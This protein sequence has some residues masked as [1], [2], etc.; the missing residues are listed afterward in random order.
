MRRRPPRSTRTDTLCPYTTLFRSLHRVG[1][2]AVAD[3]VAA[4]AG[5]GRG[6][7]RGG[8]GQPRRGRAGLGDAGVQR[9][10]DGVGQEPVGLDHQRH[11]RRLDRDLHVVEADL[12][13]V[14]QLHLGRLDHRLG[15]DLTAVLLVELRVEAAAV[16]ADPDRYAAVLALLGHE[17][18][19]LGLAAVARVEAQA[20]DTGLARGQGH[21]VLV[22][23]FGA[24][25]ARRPI[26]A[27]AETL[28]RPT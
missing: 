21:A 27:L 8:L 9:A 13:E 25:L 11:R 2:E 19:V 4:A 14:G 1:G 28:V 3:R 22:V 7:P 20:V 23:G 17:L 6:P 18:D 26:H 12:A 24:D 5:G 10:V 15:G 16:D